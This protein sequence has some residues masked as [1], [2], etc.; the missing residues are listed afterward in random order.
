MNKEYALALSGGGYRATLFSLGSLWRLNEFGLLAQI[1]RITSVSGSSIVSAFLAKNWSELK[2]KTGT[3]IFENFPAVI[4]E[5]IRDF[6]SKSLDVKAGI[7]G[8]FSFRKSIGD[9]IAEAYAKRLFGSSTLQDIPD[10]NQG[11]EFI[12]YATSMQTGASVRIAKE[13]IA[14][15]NVGEWPNSRISLAQIVGASSAFPP[16]LS[17]VTIECEPSDWKKTKGAFLYDQEEFRKKLVLTD[18][19]VYDNMGL[20]AVWNDGFKNVF[21]CNA[22]A[23]LK[24]KVNPGKNWASQALRVTSIITD[25]TRALRKR[26]LIENYLKKAYGGAYWGIRVKIDDY[27]L[28]DAMVKDNEKTSSL[29]NVRTRL[30]A[31]SDEEQGYLINWGYALTDAALRR[32]YFTDRQPTGMWPIPEHAL[33][34]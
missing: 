14:D 15:Y 25:Q 1:N 24:L 18:G 31:H 33:D 28:E 29:Q 19:G 16:V 32:W 11:P 4:A 27:K 7:S 3:T 22:S 17:P 34:R 12:F 23:P 5:P 8:I 20:E 9:K 6:C 2:F 26:T 30:N 21:V 10:L 13:W